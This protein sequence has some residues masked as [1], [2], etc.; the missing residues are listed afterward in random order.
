[1]SSV[2][3]HA[4]NSPDP[5]AVDVRVLHRDKHPV[6]Y[7]LVASWAEAS[8]GLSRR[9]P[10]LADSQSV[11]RE[12]LG[13]SLPVHPAPCRLLGSASLAAE[14]ASDMAPA[15]SQEGMATASLA[16][17]CQVAHQGWDGEVYPS[18]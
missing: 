6:V 2:T 5:A 13:H 15:H 10:A 3:A 8:L 1:M 4:A 11:A 16:L 7:R 14:P 17:Q 9:D 12:G 18:R